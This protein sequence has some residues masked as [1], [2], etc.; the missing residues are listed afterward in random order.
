VCRAGTGEVRFRARRRE[1]RWVSG[2]SSFQEIRLRSGARARSFPVSPPGGGSLLRPLPVCLKHSVSSLHAAG[3]PFYPTDF[4]ILEKDRKN[5]ETP[6]S[7][8]RNKM[9]PAFVP[10]QIP[11]GAQHAHCAGAKTAAETRTSPAVPRLYAAGLAAECSLRFA[12]PGARR[13][14]PDHLDTIHPPS[15]EIFKI[16]PNSG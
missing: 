16:R 15:H 13:P 12:K 7:D 14:V 1:V 6:A 11:M 4:G 2:A 3:P 10:S 9:H 5:G 8:S